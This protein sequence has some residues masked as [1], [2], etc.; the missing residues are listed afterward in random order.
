LDY[1]NLKTKLRSN[2]FYTGDKKMAS[3]DRFAGTIEEISELR[4]LNSGKAVTNVTV[5]RMQ[6]IISG[7]KEEVKARI[8][9]FADL[10]EKAH[11]E[12]EKG[13]VVMFTNCQRNPRTYVTDQGTHVETVDVVS[14]G[15]VPLTKTQ[16]EKARDQI[17]SLSL[18]IEDLQF[19]DKDREVIKAAMADEK[20]D[21][22]VPVA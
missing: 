20:T 10:A 7:I 9:L 21:I 6:E 3:A 15:F 16:Y 22:D 19:T 2:N 5:S 18:K 17:D 13:K 1:G 14:R 8:V 12:L 11:A 4:V